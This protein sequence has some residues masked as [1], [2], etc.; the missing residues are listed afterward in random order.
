MEASDVILVKIAQTHVFIGTSRYTLE[1][2][3]ALEVEWWSE[4]LLSPPLAVD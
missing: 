2:T 3:K 1:Q 4:S